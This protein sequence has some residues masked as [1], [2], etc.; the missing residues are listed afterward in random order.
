MSRQTLVISGHP[1]GE[2]LCEALA[3]TYSG[4]RHPVLKLRELAFDPVLHTGYSRRQT[5][6]PDLLTAQNKISA[7]DHLVLVYPIWWGTLPALMKGFFDRILLPG[8]AWEKQPGRPFPKPL[9]KGKTA[10]LIVTMD[11]PAWYHRLARDGHKIMTRG[12]LAYCGIKTV[13]ITEFTWVKNS[14]AEKRNKWLKRVDRMGY[15]SSRR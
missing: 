14:G 8:F 5:L 12:I 15:A 11:G 10:E 2:S 6:E 13:R 4:G 7:A 9:L 1:N 3:D